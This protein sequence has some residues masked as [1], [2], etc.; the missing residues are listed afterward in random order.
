MAKLCGGFSVCAAVITIARLPNSLELTI[1]CNRHVVPH[2]YYPF[3]L[4][5]DGTQ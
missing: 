1:L 3:I 4:F 2:K 5:A